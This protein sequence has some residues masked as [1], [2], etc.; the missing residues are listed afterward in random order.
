MSGDV[1]PDKCWF[2]VLCRF[3][4]QCSRGLSSIKNRLIQGQQ[5]YLRIEND[6]FNSHSFQFMICNHSPIWLHQP[7]TWYNVVKAR[8]SL[9]EFWD[10]KQATELNDKQRWNIKCP[11]NVKT[12][13]TQIRVLGEKPILVPHCPPQ[14]SDGPARD[15]VCVVRCRRPT[16]WPVARPSC[17]WRS[18]KWHTEIQFLLHREKRWCSL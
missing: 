17:P 11:R 18:Y 1:C 13:Q 5:A 15:R 16:A 7:L 2:A 9:Q 12:R 4:L 3:Y 8:E 14:I 10:D 6:C